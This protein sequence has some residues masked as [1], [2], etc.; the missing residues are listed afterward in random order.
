MPCCS[1]WFSPGED[2]SRVTMLR[3]TLGIPFFLSPSPRCVTVCHTVSHCVAHCV[4][5]CVTLCV[6]MLCSLLR[7]T[8]NTILSPHCASHHVALHTISEVLSFFTLWY[9]N[10]QSTYSCASLFIASHFHGKF[11]NNIRESILV[12]THIIHHCARLDVTITEE[13]WCW[14]PVERYLPVTKR[15]IPWS[16]HGYLSLTMQPL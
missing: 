12:S 8:S 16:V 13:R 4:S 3:C 2:M 9:C 14:T 15:R 6:T 5:H 10:P 7:R 11:L 1:F